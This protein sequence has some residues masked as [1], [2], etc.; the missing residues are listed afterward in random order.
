ML[1]GRTAASQGHLVQVADGADRRS[2]SASYCYYLATDE[3]EVSTGP[4]NH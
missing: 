3:V 4:N 1:A 2:R